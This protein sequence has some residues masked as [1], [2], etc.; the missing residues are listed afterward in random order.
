M[1]DQIP[2]ESRGVPIAM[3]TVESN[4]VPLLT[5]LLADVLERR[6]ATHVSELLRITGVAHGTGTRSYL[7]NTVNV[8]R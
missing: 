4:E 5:H 6:G 8:C 1:V 3:E 2:G 7:R